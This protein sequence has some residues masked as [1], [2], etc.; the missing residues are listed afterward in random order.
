MSVKQKMSREKLMLVPSTEELLTIDIPIQVNGKASKMKNKTESCFLCIHLSWGIPSKE[1]CR[2][3]KLTK[4][5]AG[6]EQGYEQKVWWGL[7]QTQKPLCSLEEFDLKYGCKQEHLIWE[8]DSS[9]SPRRLVFGWNMMLRQVSKYHTNFSIPFSSRHTVFFS[10][11][12]LT[13]NLLQ[14]TLWL[15]VTTSFL[16]HQSWCY[17]F[18]TLPNILISRFNCEAHIPEFVFQQ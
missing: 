1:G 13:L 6:I 11:Y 18:P 7:Q 17:F 2:C 16:S 15:H 5:P 14:I 4:I 8:F 3:W 9:A 10:I 12:F